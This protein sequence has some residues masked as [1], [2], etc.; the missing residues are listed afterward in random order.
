MSTTTGDITESVE[1]KLKALNATEDNTT[2]QERKADMYQH[3][4]EAKEE[5][6]TQVYFLL[7]LFSKAFRKFIVFYRFLMQRL[8]N[9]RKNKIKRSHT[10]T[11][12]LKMKPW[13]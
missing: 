11:M 1:K 3:I 6:F 12:K 4:K 5:K 13:T 10:K 2:E 7:R 8:K 9:R